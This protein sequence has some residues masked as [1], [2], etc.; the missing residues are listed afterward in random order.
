MVI[1]SHV[2]D[3]QAAL[4]PDADVLT[5]LIGA[6]PDAAVFRLDRRGRIRS[7]SGPA[8]QLFGWPAAEM[9]G[10]PLALLL[11][12]GTRPTVATQLRRAIGESGIHTEARFRRRDGTGLSAFLSLAAV[13]HDDGSAGGFWCVVRDGTADHASKDSIEASATLLRSILATVPDAM[14]VIDKDG[15][16]E[17]FSATAER[18]FGYG[19]AEVIGRNVSML[20]PSPDGDRHDTYMARY[21]A[22]GD[23]RI[24]GKPR[25][26]IGRRKDGSTFPHDLAIGEAMAGGRHVFAGFVR[27]LTQLE[28]AEAQLAEV[29]AELLHIARVSAMGTM[30]STL[31]HELNQPVTAVANYVETSH[32]LLARD[33]RDTITIVREALAEAASEAQRAGKIVRRLREFVARGEIDKSCEQL[34]ELVDDAWALSMVGTTRPGIAVERDID[35][36]A[37]PVLVDRVQ[38]QQ[39]LINLLRNA[40]EAIP[41]D[42]RGIIRVLVRP[43]GDFAKV[44]VVDNGSGLAPELA[45]Q[46]F[47]AFVS[48]KRDGMGLGLSICRTI[49]EAHGGRIW[50]EPQPVGMAMHF[51]LPRAQVE[52]DD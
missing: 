17:S 3:D 39:V 2:S 7:W 51:T 38:M 23:R 11:A 24:I 45:E 28:A 50:A 14:I 32:A 26:V 52:C 40:A 43:A 6:I 22:T 18:L 30:A 19:E 27:D 33:D 12:P 42:R 41:E 4:S 36:T 37:S 1:S 5:A 21:L 10:Q 16:I 44:T 47:T 15:L 35:P 9:I 8:A 20:M 48:T 25:R 46:L 34:A 31:A 13:R 29:Q 49:V